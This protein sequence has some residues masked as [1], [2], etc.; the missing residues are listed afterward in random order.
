[1]QFAIGEGEEDVV[2]GRF[3]R[4]GVSDR[5]GLTFIGDSVSTQVGLL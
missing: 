5:P 2:C 1:M 3:Q 4:A